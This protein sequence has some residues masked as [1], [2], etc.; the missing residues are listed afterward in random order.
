MTKIFVLARFEIWGWGV[1]SEKY[2]WIVLS[3]CCESTKS[4]PKPLK[5]NFITEFCYII[6]YAC[7]PAYNQKGVI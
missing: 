1:E 4:Y 7:V 5:R 2:L 3:F 6:N